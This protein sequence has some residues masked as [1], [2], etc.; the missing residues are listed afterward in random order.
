MN[1]VA[2]ELLRHCS[3]KTLSKTL[4]S[5]GRLQSLIDDLQYLSVAYLNY[6]IIDKTSIGRTLKEFCEFLDG[7][8]NSWKLQQ[9][10]KYS[11]AALLRM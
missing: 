6:K 5:E 4:K 2:N 10:R 9:L 1:R 7:L 8:D 11:N 3:G